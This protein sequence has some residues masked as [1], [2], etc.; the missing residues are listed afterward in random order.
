MDSALRVVI[1]LPLQELW[2]PDGFATTNRIRA[3][4][5]D[6]IKSLL[7]SGPVQFVTVDVGSSP[8]WIPVEDG[9]EYWKMEIKSHLAEI[10]LRA[11]L[12]QFPDEYCYFASQ[13]ESRGPGAAVV[14]LEKHH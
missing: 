3:L 11:S 10:E 13:W 9:H 8:R 6:E 2:W 14:V 4:S 7:R 12:N 1:R 5:K